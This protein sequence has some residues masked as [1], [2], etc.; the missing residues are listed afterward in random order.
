MITALAV[1]LL[2]F[3]PVVF[4]VQ[5]VSRHSKRCSRPTAPVSTAPRIT[6]TEVEIFE[7]EIEGCEDVIGALKEEGVGGV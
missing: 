1:L 6:K 2:L 7:L 5:L 3:A 4:A